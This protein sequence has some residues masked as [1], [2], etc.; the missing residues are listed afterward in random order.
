MDKQINRQKANSITLE[1]E[2]NNHFILI[3]GYTGSPTDFNGF[4]R[5]IHKKLNTNVSV[6]LLRGHGTHIKDLSGLNYQDFYTQIENEIISLLDKGKKVFLGGYSF[7]GSIALEL[8]G[9]HAVSGVFTVATPYKLRFPMSTTF[10]SFLAKTRKYWPKKLSPLEKKL[11]RG[12]FYYNAMPGKALSIVKFA[13]N[14]LNSV[15][16]LVLCPCL[17]IQSNDD[18]IAHQRGAEEINKK[19]GSVRKKVVILNNFIHGIFYTNHG[20]VVADEVIDFFSREI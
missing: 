12:A 17:T 11:R 5:T 2:S 3:H 13:N 16:P 1:C 8:A 9:K 14:N 19:I 20:D 4:P 6:P 15:L 18:P 10:G 7:G